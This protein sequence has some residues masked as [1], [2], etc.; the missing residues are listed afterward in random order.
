[1]KTYYAKSEG[2]VAGTYRKQGEAIQMS[3]GQAK[4]ETNLS[5]EKPKSA[6]KPAAKAEP[7]KK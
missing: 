2:W 3:E 5:T 4:Y 7:A 1:M 6:S